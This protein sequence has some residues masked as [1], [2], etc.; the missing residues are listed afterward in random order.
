MKEAERAIAEYC[1]LYALLKKTDLPSDAQLTADG[2]VAIK[3]LALGGNKVWHPVLNEFT[4]ASSSK[5]F[6]EVTVTLT[7]INLVPASFKA[8]MI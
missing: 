6:D 4:S 5:V 8:V 7:D 1:Y 3:A 2:R